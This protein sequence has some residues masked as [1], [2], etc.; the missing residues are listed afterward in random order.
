[1]CSSSVPTRYPPLPR[2]PEQPTSN[3]GQVSVNGGAFQPTNGAY[4]DTGGVTGA[5]PTSLIGNL[6]PGT[7]VPPGTVITVETTNGMDDVS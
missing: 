2:F 7:D 5:L 6:T 3:D 4:V 1:M